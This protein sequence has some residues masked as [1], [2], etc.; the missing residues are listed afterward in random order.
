MVSKQMAWPRA[1]GAA[2][3]VEDPPEFRGKWCWTIWVVIES[4][5]HPEMPVREIHSH[6][7]E[8]QRF[9]DTKEAAIKDMEKEAIQVCRLLNQACGGTGEEGFLD[10]KDGMKHKTSFGGI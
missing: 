1:R 10:M 6:E 4:T 5:T 3:E 8:P 2:G 9:F 7:M